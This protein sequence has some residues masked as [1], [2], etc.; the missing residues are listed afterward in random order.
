MSTVD[1]TLGT[2][3]TKSNELSAL[4][5]YNSVQMYGQAFERLALLINYKGSDSFI[6]KASNDVCKQM[7]SDFDILINEA[8]AEIAK[9]KNIIKTK[10]PIR[11]K[12][13]IVKIFFK[14][15]KLFMYAYNRRNGN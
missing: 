2:I 3:P 10:Y 5:I 9:A 12:F 11:N 14:N 15:P 7:T 4:T 6:E 8:N 13:E 1:I